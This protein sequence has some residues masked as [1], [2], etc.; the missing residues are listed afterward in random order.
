MHGLEMPPVTLILKPELAYADCNEDIIFLVGLARRG[1]QT[2]KRPIFCRVAARAV[3]D[4]DSGTLHLKGYDALIGLYVAIAQ[5]ANDCARFGIFYLRIA[6]PPQR[7]MENAWRV[8]K[9]IEKKTPGDDL[10]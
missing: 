9:P 5:V 1:K 6:I 8:A 10:S 7:N 3:R 4:I 2:L